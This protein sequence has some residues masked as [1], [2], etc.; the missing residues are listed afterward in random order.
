[1]NLRQLIL[2][3]HLQPDGLQQELIAAV[4]AR[5]KNHPEEVNQQGLQGFTPCHLAVIGSHA[6]LIEVLVLEG[7][8]DLY[9]ESAQ[10]HT[11]LSLAAS[12][13][14]QEHLERLK[15]QKPHQAANSSN[16][17]L[18]EMRSA[19]A[20]S[21]SSRR[22]LMPQERE[23]TTTPRIAQ[24][25]K[26]KPVAEFDDALSSDD[27]VNTLVAKTAELN[28]EEKIKNGFYIYL[29]PLLKAVN[30]D[31]ENLVKMYLDEGFCIES[32][33]M[34][35]DCGLLTY[36][37]REGLSHIFSLL[38]TQG[39]SLRKENMQLLST[40]HGR[41]MIIRAQNN[42]LEKLQWDEIKTTRIEIAKL[43]SNYNELLNQYGLEQKMPLQ[44][45]ALI[46]HEKLKELAVTQK[47]PQGLLVS[48]SSLISCVDG[49]HPFAPEEAA[50]QVAGLCAKYKPF[51]I[52][53]ALVALLPE[54]AKAQKLILLYTLKEIITHNFELSLRDL[55]L[56]A[57]LILPA[58]QAKSSHKD[59]VDILRFI[60]IL[61]YKARDDLV[62]NYFYLESLIRKYIYFSEL[63]VLKL[64][65]QVSQNSDMR[66][67]HIAEGLRAYSLMLYHN[68]DIKELTSM[69]WRAPNKEQLAPSV[70]DVENYFNRL[71]HWVTSKILEH[72]D[73]RQRARF[74]KLC[75]KIAHELIESEVPD[76][77]SA[78]A[79]FSALNQASVTRLKATFG[80]L[81]R[82]TRKLQ[83]KVEEHLSPHK[84]FL[85]M[86][87]RLEKN[88]YAIPHIGVITT[89]L[90]FAY[91]N[92]EESARIMILGKV[93]RQLVQKRHQ[94]QLLHLPITFDVGAFVSQSQLISGDEE[95]YQ[96][97]LALEPRP[98]QLTL[99]TDFQVLL[100]YM[101]TVKRN[102]DQLR[103]VLHGVP[104]EGKAALE[105][106]TQWL[107][108]RY[109][110][111]K[112]TI[113]TFADI[114]SLAHS[115]VEPDG[116]Y[117]F[118]AAYYEQL[119]LPIVVQFR[120]SQ[121]ELLNTEEDKQA[122]NTHYKSD[123]KQHHK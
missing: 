74:V 58:V 102:N 53:T 13:A 7:R 11:P 12:Q 123:K 61:R 8:G 49:T 44:D 16:D 116:H 113:G 72:S 31:R 45:F 30:A 107:K 109:I 81:K 76:Y 118:N 42:I 86:R 71:S 55:K 66:A 41:Q 37:H 51:E 68:L 103:V 28:I 50:N 84:N 57:T 4:R 65:F 78:M 94:L 56:I 111:G 32:L 54:C 95:L 52:I 73:I 69:G 9:Q 98:F 59:L 29:E 34:W 39:R 101:A 89:D 115:I 75:I 38:L 3:A 67:C 2:C 60:L 92:K 122:V 63:H 114:V 15:R 117:K 79:I 64:Q 24:L 104:L 21:R 120:R 20:L 26:L 40:P 22:S 83:E 23:I 90:T 100:K 27:E 10:H 106:L 105:P 17:P 91:E 119:T 35:L 6:Q 43:A 19:R 96:Q 46:S 5:I 80:L 110:Q 70:C 97:S 112:L 62:D 121:R 25:P 99:D 93:A 77:T 87:E 36:S 47:L 82:S 1:M 85:V 18:Q 48:L 88:P 33:D 14:M 108:E